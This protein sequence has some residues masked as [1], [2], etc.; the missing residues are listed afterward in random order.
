MIPV[1]RSIDGLLNRF[2]E[3]S[4]HH[5][6]FISDFEKNI[7]DIENPLRDVTRDEEEQR[8]TAESL[9]TTSTENFD[10]TGSFGNV[11]DFN[12]RITKSRTH[13]RPPSYSSNDTNS[14]YNRV[15]S[16]SSL[17][18]TESAPP[19]R[20]STLTTRPVIGKTSTSQSVI[21]TSIQN[22]NQPKVRLT[23][24]IKPKIIPESLPTTRQ[25]PRSP[26]TTFTMETAIR[27]S[28]PKTCDHSLD[29]RV[30]S[31]RVHRRL[32]SNQ[33]TKN[34][35][36]E[37]SVISVSLASSLKSSPNKRINPTTIKTSSKKLKADNRFATDNS[38]RIPMSNYPRP[39]IV[40]VPPPTVYL[41]FPM[42]PELRSS[43]VVVLPKATTTKKPINISTKNRSVIPPMRLIQLMT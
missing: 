43:R 4:Q 18:T 13:N 17:A 16:R 14:F 5:A 39:A 2:D 15:P 20:T 12:R 40:L 34:E 19:P 42:Q 7:T 35:A 33:N 11:E 6:S 1:L 10:Q 8:K 27:L 31:K 22:L 9:L 24:K 36:S 23:T 21:S 25:Y 26:I 32:K 30:S 28:R 37:S 29:Q 3:L 41:T 38:K